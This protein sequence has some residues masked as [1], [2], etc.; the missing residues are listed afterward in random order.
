MAKMGKVSTALIMGAD[1][2]NMKAPRLLGGT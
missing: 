1:Y 2:E